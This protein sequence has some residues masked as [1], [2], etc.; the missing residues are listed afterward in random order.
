[1]AIQTYHLKVNLN[2]SKP[3]IWR[4][5]LV[6]SDV[7]L[8]DLHLILQTTMGWYNG[9]L[10]QFIASNGEY[11]VPKS[12]YNDM[13]FN[14]TIY[15][16]VK[17]SKLLQFVGN[18]MV[19]EYDFGDGWEHVVR[20][21]K[22]LPHDKAMKLPVCISGKMA[23]PPEDCGGI[24]GYKELMETLANPKSS[25]YEEMLEWVGEDFDPKE[26]DKAYINDRLKDKNYGC[27]SF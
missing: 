5:I 12:E 6:P 24:C 23:C 1:M 3:N 22:V 25:D 17:L 21:V 8:S 13:G 9:H 11:F 14:T 7:L 2:G 10:H 26:F 18:K 16:K 27:F 15:D 4:D 19:Y 20:L